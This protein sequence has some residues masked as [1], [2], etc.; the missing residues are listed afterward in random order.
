MSL[1]V[2][3]SQC[4]S[5]PHCCA[6]LLLDIVSGHSA[7]LNR[8]YPHDDMIMGGLMRRYKLPHA[9]TYEYAYVVL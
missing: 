7:D 4:K 8:R 9:S 6:A 3:C 5:P 2:R 1:H